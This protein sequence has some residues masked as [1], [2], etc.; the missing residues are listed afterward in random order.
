[1][2]E[3]VGVTVDLLRSW[4]LPDP[5]SDKEARGLVVVVGGNR[6]T[7]GAVVLAG[8]SALRVGGGKLQVVTAASV[9][10]AVATAQSHDE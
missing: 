4:P 1:M 9:A 6:S 5:G 3:A 7:P 10:V 2:S 8:E